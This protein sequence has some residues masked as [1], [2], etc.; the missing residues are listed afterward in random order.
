MSGVDWS[1]VTEA[2]GLAQKGQTDQGRT[3]LEACWAAS[4]EADH[5]V[6]CVVAHYLADLQTELDGVI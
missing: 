3:A 2:I 6:R 4:D 5:A 1:R